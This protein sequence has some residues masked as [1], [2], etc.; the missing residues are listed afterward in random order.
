MAYRRSSSKTPP[1]FMLLIATWATSR[2]VAN[3][4]SMADNTKNHQN[5]AMDIWTELLDKGNLTEI[6]FT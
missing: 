5:K 6:V 3:S 4:S 1:A 2:R